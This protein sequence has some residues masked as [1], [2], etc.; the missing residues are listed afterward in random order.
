MKPQH[1]LSSSQQ[2]PSVSQLNVTHASCTS[3]KHNTTTGTSAA[4]YYPSWHR[5]AQCTEEEID[6]ERVAS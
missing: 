4:P 5:R 6:E 2:H 3:R 1:R